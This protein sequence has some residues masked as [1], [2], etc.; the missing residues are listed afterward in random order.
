MPE[1]RGKTLEQ[2]EAAF[3]AAPVDSVVHH[4]EGKDKEAEWREGEKSEEER[5]ESR[6]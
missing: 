6:V 5:L 3:G 1:T 4:P 2:I